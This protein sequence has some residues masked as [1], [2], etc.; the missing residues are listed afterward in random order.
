MKSSGMIISPYIRYAFYGAVMFACLALLFAISRYDK[1]KRVR[2]G[3]DALNRYIYSY[4]KISGVRVTTLSQ[5]PEF[6]LYSQEEGYF[7]R[8][9]NIKRRVFDGYY[10]DFQVLGDDYRVISASPIHPLS[11]KVEF[12][13]TE[14][15]I[16]R[17][18]IDSVDAAA[19]THDE[20][21][22][23]KPVF[24]SGAI[25]TWNSPS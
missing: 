3:V 16:L 23:W 17:A 13:V 19:D 22:K 15:G 8:S 11:P 20:V 4:E 2:F 1:I 25:R 18:N 6:V 9:E 21:S 12:G 14:D 5:L 10:Y 24:D 7:F